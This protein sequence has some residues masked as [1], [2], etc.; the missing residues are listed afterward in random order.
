MGK[1]KNLLR[2]HVSAMVNGSRHVTQFWFKA[3]ITCA[4]RFRVFTATSEEGQKACVKQLHVVGRELG[5]AHDSKYGGNH[6]P[7]SFFS[8]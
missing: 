4:L 8:R 3:L 7:F 5:V 6:L 2:I 1:T